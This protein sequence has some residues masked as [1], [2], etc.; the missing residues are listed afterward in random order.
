MELKDKVVVITGGTKGFGRALAEEF[1]REG[2]KIAICSN[3][4]DEVAN[5]AKEMGVFGVYADVAKE[6]DLKFF[7]SET[8]KK[9]GQIDIW[10]NNAG[11]WMAGITEN[12]DMAEVRKMFEVSVMGTING[13]RVAL[14]LMKEKN[15]GTILNVISTSALEARTDLSMYVATKWGVNGFTKAIREENK[16]KNI[17]IFSVFPG[18]MKTD[19]FIKNPPKN[20]NDFMD[21]KDVAKKVINN[22]K[23]ANSEPELIIKRPTA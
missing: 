14:R 20:Y 15:S 9:F 4:K 12:A 2:V 11:L 21:P 7:A 18:G 22:L 19:L 1:L 6:E 16:E 17:S 8:L 5:T 10:I 13:S 23:Q 3:N